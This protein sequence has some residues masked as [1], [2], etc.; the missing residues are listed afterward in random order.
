MPKDKEKEIEVFVDVPFAE[1]PNANDNPNNLIT[2]LPNL[3]EAVVGTGNRSLRIDQNGIWLG[4]KLVANAPFNV[5]MDGLMY[6]TLKSYTVANLPTSPTAGAIAYASN[7][8]KPTES[9]GNGT[10]MLVFFDGTAWRSVADG[11][12]IAA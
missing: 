3:R 9:A 11:T 6:A 1:L 12:T 10:G 5:S 2:S 4:N 8:R 7:G